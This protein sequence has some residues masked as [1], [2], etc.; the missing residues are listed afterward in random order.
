MPL[1]LRCW[2]FKNT[3][4]FSVCWGSVTPLTPPPPK[5]N[6][7]HFPQSKFV[8][9]GI[10]AHILYYSTTFIFWFRFKDG[11]SSCL[12]YKTEQNEYF[13]PTLTAV[14][15]NEVNELRLW[16]AIKGAVQHT[17]QPAPPR[18]PPGRAPLQPPA[19]LPLAP[20]K[21]TFLAPN[22]A[23]TATI[24]TLSYTLLETVTVYILQQHRLLGQRTADSAR[25][26]CYCTVWSIVI[27]RFRIVCKLNEA[28][29]NNC[30]PSLSSC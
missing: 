11:L 20:Y 29:K 21:V 27:T 8:K 15:D 1:R 5:P 12:L 3:R 9:T 22:W 30:T 23:H 6:T 4:R 7:P 25:Q 28:Q 13:N 17:E 24:T 16:S 18:W 2:A 14:N 26:V 10:Q 19:T